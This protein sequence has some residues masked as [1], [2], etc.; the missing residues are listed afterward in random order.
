MPPNAGFCFPASRRG[1]ERFISRDGPEETIRAIMLQDSPHLPHGLRA[2]VQRR[3][4]VLPGPFREP[5]HHKAVPERRDQPPTRLSFCRPVPSPG[6]PIG[7]QTGG[8]PSQH[9]R[10]LVDGG[11]GGCR[12]DL[13]AVRLAA[14]LPGG[15]SNDTNQPQVLHTSTGT[16]TDKTCLIPQCAAGFSGEDCEAHLAAGETA[17]RMAPPLYRHQVS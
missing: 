3:G 5:V 12:R 1:F 2:V 17:I 9:D 11:G 7:I 16:F 6:V 13:R 8:V 15:P 10:T 14:Q 4:C